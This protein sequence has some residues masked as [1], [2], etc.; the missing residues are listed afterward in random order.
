MKKIIY[1]FVAIGLIAASAFTVVRMQD[2]KIADNYSVKFSTTDPASGVF[3]GLKGTVSFDENDLATSKFDVTVDVST[4]NTGNG[5]QNN[6]AKSDQWFDVAK[7]PTIHFTSSEITK[8]LGSYQVKGTLDMH[9]VQKEVVIPFTFQ[10]NT[11]T[12]SF[13]LNRNDFNINPSNTKA[14][15]V[16]KVDLVVPVTK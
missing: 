8:A 2:W 6:H 7:Y 14:G 13:E 16:I 11:F 5:M 4:I 9:G 12:G 10:N 1:P 3:T 15:S